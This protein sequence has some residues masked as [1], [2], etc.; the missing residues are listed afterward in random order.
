MEAKSVLQRGWKTVSKQKAVLA[1]LIMM[2]MMVF[3][4]HSGKFYTAY[5]WLDMLRSTAILEIV[6]F[7]V[8]VAVICGGCDLSVGGTLSLGSIVA[9][10]LINAGVPIWVA[11]LAAAACGS[12]ECYQ[13]GRAHV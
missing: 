3:L 5:N 4:D 8:S 10:M 6:A 2:V 12:Q 7:G 1:I 13:I 9:V 11:F